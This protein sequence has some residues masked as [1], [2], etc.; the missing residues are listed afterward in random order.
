MKDALP[1]RTLLDYFDY[2]AGS[3]KPNLLCSKVNG[4]WKN[5][6]AE[7]FARKVKGFALGLAT[8]G[9]DRGDRVAILSENRPEWPM[10]DFATLALGAMSVPIYITYF[11]P[12]WSTS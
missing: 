12:R 4:E 7:E 3:G 2:A 1:A 10:T 5:V 11:A 6:S 9:V 8:L